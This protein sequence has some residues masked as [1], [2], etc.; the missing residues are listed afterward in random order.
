MWLIRHTVEFQQASN[1]WD[2]KLILIDTSVAYQYFR[3]SLSFIVQKYTQNM[4]YY[5]DVLLT[6][7][8]IPDI[9]PII[10]TDFDWYRLS[11]YWNS[12]TAEHSIQL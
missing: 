3:K 9:A 2:R 7:E 12:R 11:R 8:A 6:D 10:R 4:Q 1:G 5:V